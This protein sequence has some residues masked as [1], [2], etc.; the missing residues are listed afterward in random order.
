MYRVLTAL[1][2]T[3]AVIGLVGRPSAEQS[4]SIPSVNTITGVIQ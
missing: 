1:A 4:P 3:V 2:I